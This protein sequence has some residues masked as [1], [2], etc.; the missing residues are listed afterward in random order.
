VEITVGFDKAKFMS[1]LPAERV[2]KLMVLNALRL[3]AA[4]HPTEEQKDALERFCAEAI[5]EYVANPVKQLPTS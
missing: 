3:V 2:L 1:L 4:E 5:A